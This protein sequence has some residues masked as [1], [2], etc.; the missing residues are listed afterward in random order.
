M[1][2]FEDNYIKQGTGEKYVSK[3][4][5]ASSELPKNHPIL[6]KLLH[7]TTVLLHGG[8]RV[9]RLDWFTHIIGE[10]LIFFMSDFAGHRMQ[11]EPSGLLNC[12]GMLR[13]TVTHR[14]A[15]PQRYVKRHKS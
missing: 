14:T 6:K 13:R 9:L 1:L 7:N 4:L 12:C 10:S 3:V 5:I 11:P 15:F 8:V 2:M